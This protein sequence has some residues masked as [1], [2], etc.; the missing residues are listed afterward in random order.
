MKRCLAL[1]LCM[2]LCLNAGCT[3]QDAP[4]GEHAPPAARA[5]AQAVAESQGDAHGM[6]LLSDEILSGFLNSFGLVGWEDAC[7][8]TGQGMDAREITVLRLSDETEAEAAAQ[9]LEYHR[10]Q[11]LRDFFGYAP[12]QVGLLETALVLTQ[13]GFAALLVCRDTA[14]AQAAF[15]A[16]FE[17][18]VRVHTTPEPTPE[19]SPAVTP[20]PTPE[21]T[22]LNPDLDISEFVPYKQPDLVD[23]TLYDNTALVRAWNTG[24]EEGLSDMEREIL[25]VCRE[26]FAAVVTEDMTD[27]ETELALHDWLMEHGVYDELANDNVAHEGLPHNKDPYGMLVGGYGIC[28]GFATAF[29]L[30]MELAGV[31]CIT[32]VGAAYGSTADHA[33]NMV[34]LDGAWYCVD[35]TWNNSYEDAGFSARYTHKYFNVTSDWMRES[36]H[37]WDYRNVP[38][39]TADRYSWKR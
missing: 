19:H 3:V 1:L 6:T 9:C 16:C 15:A 37:Q 17:G 11:R 4:E 2:L 27:Y 23:M 10:Q 32:V 34:K 25:Q 38:E 26:A 22:V 18:D 31:E 8:L 13:E 39:A 20:E 7:V 12:E 33:W 36:D 21:E 29:Q 28:I 14:A 24:E 5:V 35:V 30:L